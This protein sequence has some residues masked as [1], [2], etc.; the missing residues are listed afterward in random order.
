[1][2]STD[3][4]SRQLLSNEGRLALLLLL[5][6]LLLQLRLLLQLLLMLLVLDNVALPSKI[7]SSRHFVLRPCAVIAVAV[8]KEGHGRR[9]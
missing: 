5:L 8:A 4:R 2:T 9:D 7:D 6:L 3:T 1:M